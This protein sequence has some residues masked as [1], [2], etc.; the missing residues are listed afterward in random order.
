LLKNDIQ[1]SFLAL[2]GYP[3]EKGDI[4]NGRIDISKMKDV[5]KR[6]FNMEIDFNKLG[7]DIDG[8][9]KTV[10]FKDFMELMSS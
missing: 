2:G 9:G 5:V 7:L 3:D 10:S 4:T 6:N 1:N 8:D